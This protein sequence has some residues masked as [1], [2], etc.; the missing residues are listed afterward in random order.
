MSAELSIVIPAYNEET[1][2]AG[3]VRGH[4]TAGRRL[5]GILE[6]LVCDDG[7]TDGT[8]RELEAL[9]DAVPELRILT[10]DRNCGIATTMR[11]L[12]GAASGEWVYFAP[13]DG[14]VP[15][16]A[17]EIMWQ[18]RSGAAAVVGRRVPRRDPLSRLLMAELYSAIL[19][20]LF[21]LPVRDI[22][23][24][25]LYRGRELRAT[26]MRSKSNFLEAEILI[27]LD[28][29]RL[30]LREI[31]IPHRPRIA[32]RAK[33]V[34]FGAVCLAG[35]EMARFVADDVAARAQRRR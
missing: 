26:T 17:L 7:S 10:N 9:R 14:Q 2:V 27:G 6:V 3:V 31:A 16:E 11:R 33:G 1:T 28:R 24:V 23:S 21:R 15:A 30:T 20:V 32:D 19:R 13:A 34:T 4:H 29:R 22:D 5:A 8:H 18:V 12:Y 35:W 25:K